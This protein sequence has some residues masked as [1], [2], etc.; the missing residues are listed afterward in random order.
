MEHCLACTASLPISHVPMLQVTM[1]LLTASAMLLP[2]RTATVL[3]V[4]PKARW[5]GTQGTRR[6]PLPWAPTR[7]IPEYVSLMKRSW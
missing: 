7:C 5:V 4:L 1:L 2:F 3:A 6:C